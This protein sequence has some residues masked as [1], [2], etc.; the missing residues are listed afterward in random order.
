M[1]TP[2]SPDDRAAL[3]RLEQLQ[4]WRGPRS[5]TVTLEPLLDPISS[6]AR[7]TERRLGNLVDLWLAHVP[8]ELTRHAAVTGFRGGTLQVTAESAAV[9]FQ[10]DRALRGGLLS[11]LRR[12]FPGTLNN[13]RI[14][15]G[16]LDDDSAST[17]N[18]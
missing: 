12:A 17:D 10:L 18:D 13:V 9:R 1:S 11:T 7:R 6:T 16:R 4:Q 5:R 8:E 3:R 2:E 15:A 14:V